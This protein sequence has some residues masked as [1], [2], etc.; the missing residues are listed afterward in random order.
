MK[1]EH[2]SVAADHVLIDNAEFHELGTAHF[3]NLGD[4][5]SLESAV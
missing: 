2:C 4:E 1:R 5:V 3:E